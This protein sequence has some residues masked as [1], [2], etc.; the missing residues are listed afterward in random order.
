MKKILERIPVTLGINL[1]SIILILFIG[2]PIGVSSA[3]RE[4]GFYDRSMTV[5]VFVGFAIPTFWLS[6]ILMDLVGV[7]WGI[8]PVSGI[9]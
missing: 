4:G 3:V 6:L 2:I 9:K 5:F 7:R 1:A 8:L